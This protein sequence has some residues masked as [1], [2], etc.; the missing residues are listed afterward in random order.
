MASPEDLRQAVAQFAAEVLAPA[1]DEVDRTGLI[2]ASHLDELA[3]L[4]LYGA[5]G[6][7][8]AGGL[9][10]D[11]SDFLQSI[12][13]LA[14]GCLATTF[15]WLQ[16]HPAVRAVQESHSADRWLADLCSGVVRAGVGVGGVRPGV[17]PL[18]VRRDGDDWL[19][20]GTVPWV[21]GWGLVDVLQVAARDEDD[22]VTW[23]LVDAEDGPGRC[24]DPVDLSVLTA[25]RTATL[26]FERH[27]VP[28]DRVTGR[29]S[30]DEWQAADVM[31]LRGA[32]SLALGVAARCGTAAPGAL[33]AV[34]RRLDAADGE[35]RVAALA[36]ARALASELALRC[37]AGAMVA[38][39]SGSVL[40]GSAA[41]RSLREAAFLLVFGSRPAIRDALVERLRR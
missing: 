6:P 32:G 33:E 27:R 15:V 21:T 37:A 9:A 19:L 28:G 31:S 38:E 4:G 16:H 35:G 30:Y 14:A 17:E 3:R 10:L 36:E 20:D 29:T 26:V 40:A 12:E 8:A 13:V 39:G 11:R 18:R 24:G 41:A 2:P 7:A 22:G 5:L 34:R 23:L 25:T 1:A